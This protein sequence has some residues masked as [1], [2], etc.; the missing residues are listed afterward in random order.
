MVGAYVAYYSERDVRGTTERFCNLGAWCVLEEHRFAGVR[1]LTSLLAQR[2]Y[3]F[4]DMSPSGNV[5]ELNKRLKFSVMDTATAL[6][7]NLP[8]PSRPGG[9]LVSSDPS[10]VREHLDDVQLRIYDD[11][12]D[13]AA[14]RHVIVRDRDRVCYLIFRHDRRKGLPVFASIL[15]ASDPQLLARHFH[16]V[17]NHLLLHHRVAFTLAELRVIGPRPR[18]SVMLE[19]PRP[20]MFKSATLSADDIDYLYTELEALPW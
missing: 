2:D 8:W 14:A 17:T 19:R 6:V 16:R 11:H 5:I 12:L 13:A 9:V 18:P 20:K 10:V 3:H 1:L 4:T 7:P 15:H